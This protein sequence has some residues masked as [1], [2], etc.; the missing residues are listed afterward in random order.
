MKFG[1]MISN[2]EGILDE[3]VSDLEL[4]HSR[5]SLSENY[6]DLFLSSH[7]VNSIGQSIDDASLAVE[8]LDEAIN[9]CK[10]IPEE[11][12]EV[13]ITV[14]ESLHSSIMN[15]LGLSNTQST[16]ESYPKNRSDWI[17]TM[18]DQR[19]SILQKIVKVI[20]AMISSVMGFL[21]NLFKNKGLLQNHLQILLARV[22]TMPDFKGGSKVTAGFK[23]YNA[24]KKAIDNCDTGM[25][26]LSD[27]V[28]AFQEVKPIL[29]NINAETSSGIEK[30]INAI[31]EEA[32]KIPADGYYGGAS[33][34]I[35]KGNEVTSI[36]Y[37]KGKNDVDS[38]SL[39]RNEVANLLKESIETIKYF[40]NINGI[41]GT[42][43]YILSV[44]KEKISSMWN[45]F[46]SSSSNEEV[47]AKANARLVSNGIQRILRLVV[48]NFTTTIPMIVFDTIKSVADYAKLSIKHSGVA[49]EGKVDQY[50]ENK[51]IR[52]KEREEAMKKRFKEMDELR[53]K[54]DEERRREREKE[55]EE[56]LKQRKE[57]EEK[58]RRE[59]EKRRAKQL[60]EVSEK[61][62]AE[63]LEL[64][65][66]EREEDE[67]HAKE[68]NERMRKR[69]EERAN[70]EK[71]KKEEKERKEKEEE[72]SLKSKYG[73]KWRIIQGELD[74]LDL[75]L[76]ELRA[77]RSVATGDE[78]LDIIDKMT[79]IRSE[80]NKLKNSD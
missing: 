46:R 23:D 57:T 51:S 65:R 77:K 78:R 34:N 47:A 66:K 17:A 2:L 40:R 31:R 5:Q 48:R 16:M 24:C 33:L 42:F 63:A 44:V 6:V 69:A 62:K 37:T 8:Q 9:V 39:S 3:D 18:E 10:S 72:E 59:E 19:D 43:K 68:F 79:D 35:T 26:L 73:D 52:E 38:T 1:K 53:A 21:T 54:E 14:L 49:V 36:H 27:V 4:E 58:Q 45:R 71:L 76:D 74:R 29:K 32:E 64:A 55:E 61:E 11:S 25:Y 13:A 70:E 41:E 56:K 75:E 22:K 15:T 12:P 67:R 28:R 50:E 60:A 80:I 30:I 7:G 20:M